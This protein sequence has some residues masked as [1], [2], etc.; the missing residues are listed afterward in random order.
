M[1]LLQAEQ[2]KYT[3][4]W[5]NPDYLKWSPAEYYEA[6]FLELAEPEFRRI[7]DLGCGQGSTTAGLTETNIVTLVD[8]VDV[9]SDE[10]KEKCAFIQCPLWSRAWRGEY[11]IAYCCDVMEHLPTEYVMLTLDRVASYCDAAFFTISNAPDKFGGG[12]LHLTVRP[13]EW[14]KERLE[15]NFDLT[16]ARDMLAQ[17]VFYGTSKA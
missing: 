11:D 3:E 2:A 16:E 12:N 7:V 6:F 13:Y 4:A 15:D 8:I 14:W 5:S 9:R 1:N 17:S 10:A